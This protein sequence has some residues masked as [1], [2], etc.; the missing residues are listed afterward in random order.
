[1]VLFF[2]LITLVKIIAFGKEP[3]SADVIADDDDDDKKDLL[4]GSTLF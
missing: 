3:L 4:D 2:D 1:M